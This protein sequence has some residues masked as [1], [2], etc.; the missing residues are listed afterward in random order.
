MEN[1]NNQSDFGHIISSCRSLLNQFRNFKISFVRRQGNY[2]AHTLARASNLDA[3][4]HIY[5]L[6]LSCIF[7]ILMNEM[8]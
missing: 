6:I 1:S 2:V 4:H 3:C 8:I 5:D 7:S